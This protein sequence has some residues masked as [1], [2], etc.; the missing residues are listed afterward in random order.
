MQYLYWENLGDIAG[1]TLLI[2]VDKHVALG[3]DFLSSIHCIKNGYTQHSFTPLFFYFLCLGLQSI[4][5]LFV[6]R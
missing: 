2:P 1:L 4:R 6:Q 3:T 5:N